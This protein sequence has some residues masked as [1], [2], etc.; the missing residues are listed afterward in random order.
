MAAAESFMVGQLSGWKNEV[1]C[2]A[3]CR[4]KL[5]DAW[6]V[7]HTYVLSVTYYQSG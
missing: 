5:T 2:R 4:E 6:N 3:L 1:L 7:F